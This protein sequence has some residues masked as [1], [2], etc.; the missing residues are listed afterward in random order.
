MLQRSQIA[1]FLCKTQAC[2]TVKNLH[3]RVRCP[4]CG[5]YRISP[6]AIDMLSSGVRVNLEALRRWIASHN[7]SGQSPMVATYIIS[8]RQI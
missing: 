6:G 2:F 7:N 4:S 5:S 1:C 3:I 8:S